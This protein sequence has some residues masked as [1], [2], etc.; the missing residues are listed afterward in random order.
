ME[1]VYLWIVEGGMVLNQHSIQA[2]YDK[3][4]KQKLSV[5]ITWCHC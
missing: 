3:E 2:K 5:E 1:D 4:Y